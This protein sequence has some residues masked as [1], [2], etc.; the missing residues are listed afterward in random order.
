MPHCS[1][2]I[3]SCFSST[4]S[5]YAS[6][7][8]GRYLF[9][10]ANDRWCVL[11]DLAD[12]ATRAAD[13]IDALAVNEADSAAAAASS[14]ASATVDAPDAV[15]DDES[16]ASAADAPA[17]PAAPAAPR[18]RPTFSA[19]E[20]E[21]FDTPLMRTRFRKREKPNALLTLSAPLPVVCIADAGAVISLH[22]VDRL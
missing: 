18:P 14:S 11:W 15:H 17:A 16:K 21:V 1:H 13:A 4:R 20:C 5:H 19:Q 6:F 3:V 7:G 22:A 10:A 2:V 9:S 12:E 8:G